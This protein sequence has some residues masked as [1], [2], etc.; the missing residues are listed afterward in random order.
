LQEA[1]RRRLAAA[2]AAEFAGEEPRM[3]FRPPFRT[4]KL[5]EER[6]RHEDLTRGLGEVGEMPETV[7]Q[8]RGR[9]VAAVLRSVGS[10][11]REERKGRARGG[12]EVLAHPL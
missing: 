7:A 1:G 4:A 3:A 6:G 10:V 12:E 11:E 5:P 9:A 8:R 2:P